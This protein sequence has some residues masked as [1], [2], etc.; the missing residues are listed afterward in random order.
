MDVNVVSDVTAIIS[1]DT[2]Q[3]PI[4]AG[5]AVATVQSSD[6]IKVLTVRG[7][8]FAAA[9]AGGSAATSDISSEASD[10]SSFVGQELTKSDR[11]ELASAPKVLFQLRNIL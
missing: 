9:E 8:A 2:F 4:Y 10:L 6:P 11:P 3:R 5:N 1:A 7:T